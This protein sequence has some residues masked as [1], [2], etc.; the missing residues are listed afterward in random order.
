MLPKL[1][2]IHSKSAVEQ[3]NLKQAPFLYH[4]ERKRKAQ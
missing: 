4:L 3:L 2:F 1:Q